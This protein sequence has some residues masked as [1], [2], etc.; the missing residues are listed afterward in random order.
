M[1]LADVPFPTCAD[2]E[3]AH[4]RVA[5]HIRRTPI[6]TSEDLDALAGAR[7]LFKCENFQR[8]GAFKA[9]G[10]FNAILSFAEDVAARGVVTHSSGNHAL[11][12]ALAARTR[13]IP[14]TIVMPRTAPAAKRD[15]VARL[16]AHIVEVEPTL[17]AREAGA[18]A[19]IAETGAAFVHP[20]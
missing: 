18:E 11:A 7:L 15:G 9:R 19:I 20:Y 17:A 10:A 12:V 8:I 6:L 13:G 3:A 5:P 2:V 1:T 16:G 14:A 4:R